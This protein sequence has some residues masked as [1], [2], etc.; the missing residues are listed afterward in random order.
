MKRTSALCLALLFGLFGCGRPPGP[1]PVKKLKADVP[2][3]AQAEK[4][5]RENPIGPGEKTKVIPL[6]VTGEITVLLIQTHAGVPLHYHAEHEETVVILQGEGE[7]LIADKPGADQKPKAYAAR[8]GSILFA[9]RG[10]V[11]G[12]RKTGQGPAAALSIFSPPFDGK[13]R[14]PVK[15][16]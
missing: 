2:F 14:V 6:R 10:F 4:L 12:F 13:D 15:Q 16:E 8:P 9:P 3:A 5:L 1:A 7:N 11:H